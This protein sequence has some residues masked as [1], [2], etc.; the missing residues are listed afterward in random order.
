MA[1]YE[2]NCGLNTG[3]VRG[4]SG[5]RDP[6]DYL[7]GFQH[8]ILHRRAGKI[9]HALD[10]F[11]G[12]PAAFLYVHMYAGERGAAEAAQQFVV[13]D[14]ELVERLSREVEFSHFGQTDHHHTICRFVTSWATTEEEID[15]LE[16]II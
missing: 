9:D 2:L 6:S 14:N 1:M 5:R 12:L 15:F 3:V 8:H 11:C 10:E 7:H 4:V 13:I 16:R